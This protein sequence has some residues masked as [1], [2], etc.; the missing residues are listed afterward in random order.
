MNHNKT[1]SG[2]PTRASQEHLRPRSRIG[3]FTLIEL[4]VT[5]TVAVILIA[6]A[7]PSFNYMTVSNKLTTTANEVVTALNTA[8]LEGVKR[9]NQVTVCSNTGNGADTLGTA[10]GTQ[11][12]AVYATLPNGTAT[13]V[14]AG[15]VGIAP[16]VS[17]QS[18]T[19]LNF[20][21]QGLGT[22][23]GST[24]PY[25]GLVAELYTDKISSNNHRCIYMNTGSVV[26]SCTVT[27]ACPN[28]L[29][30]PCNQ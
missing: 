21:G 22:G 30:N 28:A 25:T 8:R 10:C 12:G 19:R 13:Q 1:T 14:R 26:R 23:V 4:M 29:P 15:I 7:I 9:N 16:P 5:L 18:F 11:T 24:T 3:G 6:I 2:L 27:G 17:L 20:S